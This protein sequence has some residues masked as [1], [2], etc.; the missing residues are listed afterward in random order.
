MLLLPLEREG[1]NGERF[2]L[3]LRRELEPSLRR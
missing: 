1:A 3:G 2:R